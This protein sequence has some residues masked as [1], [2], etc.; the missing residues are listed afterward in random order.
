[1][2]KIVKPKATPADEGASLKKSTIVEQLLTRAEGAS[3]EE[4]TAATAWQS[5]SCRA[6][7][8]GLRKK[9]WAIART[10]RDDGPTIWTGRAPASAGSAAT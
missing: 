3:L 1:M 6:F 4:L 7:L 5:H 2:T 10:K 8:T 9:G